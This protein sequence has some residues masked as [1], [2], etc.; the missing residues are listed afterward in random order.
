MR[1]ENCRQHPRLKYEPDVVQHA[2]DLR[3]TG[4]SYRRVAAELGCSEVS[5]R[6][7]CAGV[8]R[9]EV[10]RPRARPTGTRWEQMVQALSA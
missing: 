4:L 1:V 7:W 8:K 9:P 10:T 6:E 3:A 5:V 2:V